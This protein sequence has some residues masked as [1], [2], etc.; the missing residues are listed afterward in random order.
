MRAPR[1]AETLSPICDVLTPSAYPIA[2]Y[3]TQS[4]DK[5]ARCCGPLSQKSVCFRT[6][7]AVLIGM[8]ALRVANTAPPA[9]FALALPEWNAQS[10]EGRHHAP[11][12]T[13]RALSGRSVSDLTGPLP[14]AFRTWWHSPGSSALAQSGHVARVGGDEDGKGTDLG[15]S[16]RDRVPDS[17]ARGV[18]F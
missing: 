11:C 9:H 5:A 10:V 3:H 2:R 15:V 6:R 14:K 8:I 17:I 7:K 12:E 16:E 1:V 4:T 13:S 18:P